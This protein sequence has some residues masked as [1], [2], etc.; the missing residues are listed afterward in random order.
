MELLVVIG[1]VAAIIYS[2]RW[3]RQRAQ[4]ARSV[5]P[6]PSGRPS[7][8]PPPTGRPISRQAYVYAVFSAE[9]RDGWPA[10]VLKAV[11]GIYEVASADEPT[12]L[13]R[14]RT[15]AKRLTK[16]GTPIAEYLDP[17]V[18]SIY[19]AQEGRGE[20]PAAAALQDLLDAANDLASAEDEAADADDEVEVDV[21]GYAQNFVDAWQKAEHP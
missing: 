4:S 19:E 21:I 18:E 8:P 15:V 12:T 16:L 2:R 13:G 5:P 1:I 3:S 7:Q 11:E 10:S 9:G 20:D 6:P 17:I 14:M